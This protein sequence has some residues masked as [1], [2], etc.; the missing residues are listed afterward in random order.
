MLNKSAKK[1]IFKKK[2]LHILIYNYTAC[3]SVKIY[4]PCVQVY[5]LV[6]KVYISTSIY[7]YVHENE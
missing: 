5:I 3:M 4:K 7:W 6:C 1:K 2:T